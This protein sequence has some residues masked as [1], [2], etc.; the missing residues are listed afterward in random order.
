MG[1]TSL[2]TR[3]ATKAADK[4]AK[5]SSLSLEQLE[6][7]QKQRELYLSEKP[8]TNDSEAVELTD[9]L[10]ATAATE[11]YNAYLPQIDS[12]YTPIQNYIEYENKPFNPDMNICYVKITKWVV[13]DTENSLEKLINV[14]E[15]LSEEKCN[16]GLIFHREHDKTDVYLSVTDLENSESK[17]NINTYMDRLLSAV[18]GN[19]PGSEFLLVD[20]VN[21][22]YK[23]Y[24]VLS[25]L[26]DTD[27]YSVASITN[28][29]T[30]KSEKFISQTIEKLLDGIVPTLNG[31][32][33]YTIILL[34]TPILD[35][36]DR[37][38]HLAEIYSGLAPYAGWQTNFTFTDSSSTNSMATF[39]VNVGASAGVQNGRNQSTTQNSA[40]TESEGTS[41]MNSHSD[42]TGESSSHMKG[43][44]TSHAEG[45]NSS[46]TDTKG[47][48]DTV[49]GSITAGGS[50][51]VSESVGASV[52]V[53]G[54][55]VNAS[56]GSTQT[57]FGS[58]TGSYNHGWNSS[59]AET[60]G[61][62]ISD[63]IGRSISN[64]ISKN[65]AQTVTHAL[66][67]T[68]GKALTKGVAE[69]IGTAKNVSLGANFGANFARSS[70]VTATVGKNE[71]ITQSFTNYNIKHAL[72][73]LEVLMKRLDTSS[74]LGCWDFGAYIISEDPNIVNNVAHS[75]LALTQGEE[76]YMSQSAINYWRGDKGNA[77]TE[78]LSAK[79]ICSYISELRHPLFA[80]D[81]NIIKEQPD[82]NIYPTV[83]TATTGLSGKELSYSLNFPKKSISGLPVIRCA[84][85]G[86]SISRFDIIEQSKE[87]I[88]LG[89]I[90]HMHHEEA[91][92]FELDKKSLAS[93]TFITGS[94]GSGKSNTIYQILKETTKDEN[95]KFMVIEPAK[96]EYKKI[97]GNSIAHVYGTNKKLS[98]LL[99]INPFSFPS[100]IH[101][102]EHLDRLIEIFNVC[103][104]MYAAMPA[105]LKEAVEKSYEDAG[106]N[107][108]ESTN[109][110]GENLYPTFADVTRNIRTIID[111]SDYD[112]ENKGAYK[113]SLITRLKSLTNGINGQI[114]TTDE[115]SDKELFEENV[116]IDLSRVGSIETKSLIMGL[117]VLK[118]QEYRIIQNSMDE[119][120]Q[121]ITVLEEAHNLLKRTSTGIRSESSNILG[122]SVEMLTNAIAEMRTYGEGFIIADQAPGLLDMAVIR[123]TNT[124]II[125]RLPDL[126]DR[127][128]VG[129]AANLN[130]NQIEELAKLPCGVAAVYQNDWIQPVLCKI[131]KYDCTPC[132]DYQLEETFVKNETIK[133]R[134]NLAK[135]LCQLENDSE[136]IKDIKKRFDQ[137]L[138]SKQLQNLSGSLYVS[139]MQ[140]INS[141]DRKPD[142]N[143]LSFI[144]SNLFPDFTKTLKV[145]SLKNPSNVE[146]WRNDLQ[147]HI[148]SVLKTYNM[149]SEIDLRNNILQCV[150][151]NYILSEINR[152][153][154]L[155]ELLAKKT[156]L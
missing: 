153:N 84:E 11:I 95:T 113:G 42:T 70:N 62:N 69:T 82:F 20:S 27:G 18:K 132:F 26:K 29:P 12:L 8:D 77:D 122:K 96:G 53:G 155:N 76:S 52:G 80:L 140:Y 66:T 36:E 10:L 127:E 111:S 9:R 107:L 115:L 15:V 43:V 131:D 35:V 31:K 17:A 50:V 133:E 59:T 114:F 148:E 79:E 88:R 7:V 3:K 19:F 74:A 104:P 47:H 45:Q 40:T 85:F 68:L 118:L 23:N 138:S 56:V 124:K 125:M 13:D 1:I 60:T 121:H 98:A 30:E 156:Q 129:K 117:L 116:I 102:L 21:K 14:Y 38:L 136:K 99:K 143:K 67:N 89:K 141:V 51:S 33:D 149:Q 106:W 28:I 123:N 97:F 120:L 144:V 146:I 135:A 46:H 6:N 142:F 73:K 91:S 65:T 119:D 81:E 134:I 48:S 61:K 92:V 58:V 57:G 25:F 75:Y 34:A 137:L 150:L 112:A 152:P 90:F 139:V 63:T 37:K 55:G 64:T 101:I 24:G 103:W 32:S 78:S 41:E 154:L 5:L 71:G 16:I 93:H 54:T 147:E 130:D 100:D 105:V 110:Y 109:D 86:R 2:I 22:S 87:S 128:L 44:N 108:A 83:V 126:G 72:E 39:G 49:G 151:Q 94:T 4:I 145:S